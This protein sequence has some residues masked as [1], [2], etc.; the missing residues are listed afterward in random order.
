MDVAGALPLLTNPILA[1]GSDEKSMAA[2]QWRRLEA[3][4]GGRVAGGWRMAN[5]EGNVS[6]FA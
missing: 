2:E 4:R 5:G 1:L 3:C 6:F